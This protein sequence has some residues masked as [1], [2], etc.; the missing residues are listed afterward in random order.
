MVVC[1]QFIDVKAA[2][3]GGDKDYDNDEGYNDDDDG[4]NDNNKPTTSPTPSPAFCPTV[5]RCTNDSQFKVNK[6]NCESYLENKKNKKC[7]EFKNGILV[8]DSCPEICKK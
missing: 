4:D 3:C 8:A 7:N 5:S 2:F 6:K 1:N